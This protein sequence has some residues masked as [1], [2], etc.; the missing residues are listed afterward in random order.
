MLKKN[1]LI[2]LSVLLIWG[3]IGCEFKVPTMPRLPARWNSKVIIPLLDETYSFL[4]MVYDSTTTRNNSIYADTLHRMYYFAVD[5]PGQTI[6]VADDYW[7]IQP[8]TI[9]KQI[10][11]S[12]S[13]DAVVNNP[14]PVYH[15]TAQGKISTQNNRVIRGELNSDNGASVNSI[16][17]TA[18]LS[19]TL[20]NDVDI[21]IVARNFKNLTTDTIWSGTLS[22]AAD[23]LENSITF[24]V[25]DDSLFSSDRTAFIDSLDFGLTVQ[26][27]DTLQEEL[28]QN[29]VI[30][31]DV[32]ELHMDSFYGKVNASGYLTA[33]QLL[34]SPAGADSILFNE[35]LADFSLSDPGSFESIN[36]LITGKK[37]HGTDTTLDSIF[38]ISGTAYRLDIASVM[39]NLPD[40]ITFY[41]EASLPTDQYDG[42]AMSNKLTIG[43]QLYAPLRITLPAEMYL[44]AANPTRF[45]IKDSL[46][47]SNVSR[48]QN[49]A[50]FDISVTNRTPFSGSIYLLIGNHREFPTDSAEADWYSNYE[51]INDTLYYIAADT[52]MVLIDTLAVIDLP[53]AQM[54]NDT[55]LY[56]GVGDVFYMADSSALALLADTCYILPKFY[57]TNPDTTQVLLRSNYSIGLKTYMNLLFDPSVLN[58]TETDTTD[59]TG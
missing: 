3:L 54:R 10:D 32:A 15:N 37:Q 25:A 4:D 51:Y 53:L 12:T 50:Q 48:S 8:M 46:T 21:E 29:L 18:T 38:T 55:L 39:S 24:D 7:K 2:Y 44:T 49:G 34:S 31:I 19:D 42:S 16:R 59:T 22:L 58:Q 56:A 41:I 17:I 52:E 23:V 6:T 14:V 1:L 9:V 13:I 36:F 43:Y 20:F 11:L 33:Q 47:R 35:A 30:R 57:L 40:S 27:Q 45:F 26:I 5:T 28:T